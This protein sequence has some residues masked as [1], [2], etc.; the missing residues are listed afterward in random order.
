MAKMDKMNSL[1]R[2][3]HTLLKERTSL[4]RRLLMDRVNRNSRLIAIK[5]SRGVGKTNFLLDY[6]KEFH[7]S[8]DSCLYVNVN[9]LFIA[10]DG[11]FRFVEHFYK[12]GGKVLLL[13][14][15]HKY[16]E[17]DK[18]L[19][20]CYDSFPDL[21]IVFTASSIVRIK[22]NPY[23]KDV[24]DMYNLSG[25]SFREFL[26]LETGESFPIFSFQEIVE[27]HE[28][29][30]EDIL[31]LVRPLAYFGNY[32]E[33][34]YYPIYLQEKSHIDYLLKN[35]NLTLEFDIP[36]VSQIELKYLVKLKQLLYVAARD[37]SCNVNISKLSSATGVSRATVLN[38][39]NYMKDARLLTLLYDAGNNDDCGKKP[40]KLYIHNP[41]LLNAVCLDEVD[42]GVLR[43]SFFLSQLC[44]VSHINYTEQ[45]DFFVDEKYEVIVC[46]E[47]KGRHLDS[48]VIIMEDMIEKG[49]KNVIP[50]W[51]SGFTY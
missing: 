29:I 7:L 19:R 3:H 18:E 2:T 1:V 8:E 20:E 33:Y 28:E 47:G 10:Y 32:L 40:K 9:N 23:L 45:A 49:K 16:P 43:K 25:L 15:I 31:K 13:D 4:I 30:V 39:L 6:C 42:P 44:P 17:W 21:Q 5:G 41:N 46:Q 24:V 14:Q 38:Y 11:L 36:Y 37:T 27:R 35:I 51:L 12:L 50:L 22:S 34:G 26:E 48:S